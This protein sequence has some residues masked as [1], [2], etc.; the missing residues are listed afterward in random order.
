MAGMQTL[1]K[2]ILK[3]CKKSSMEVEFLSNFD[4]ILILDSLSLA[5]VTGILLL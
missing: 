2:K 3:K 5:N 4:A 1:L